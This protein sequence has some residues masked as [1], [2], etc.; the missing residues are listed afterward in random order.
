ML[1]PLSAPCG[2]S[3]AHGAR[4]RTRA[5]GAQD[6][7]PRAAHISTLGRQR[8][9]TT[10]QL[11][12]TRRPLNRP[13]T[14]LRSCEGHGISTEPLTA[15]V[16][17]QVPSRILLTYNQA[18]DRSVLLGHQLAQSAL[19]LRRDVPWAVATS[20]S[21]FAMGWPKPPRRRAPLT[22]VPSACDCLAAA[23]N[24]RVSFIGR[25]ALRQCE[26]LRCCRMLR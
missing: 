14:Y 4:R 24:F 16:S 23:G 11:H 18:T 2:S 3:P 20:M 17:R 10:A 12:T 15:R 22:V 21:T 13:H 8:S 1:A 9:H 7:A 6:S 26:D 5:E 19:T 25:N